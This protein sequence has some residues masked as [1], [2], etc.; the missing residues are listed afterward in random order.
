[1]RI[2]SLHRESTGFVYFRSTLDTGAA[3]SQ[4]FFGDPGDIIEAGDWNGDGTDT[5]AVY[6]PSNGT[7]YLKLANV[8]G[9]ADLS[10]SVGTGMVGFG[11]APRIP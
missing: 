1:M 7:V 2:S 5:V 4:F 3:N 8:Q 10:F 11:T 9:N 6:R